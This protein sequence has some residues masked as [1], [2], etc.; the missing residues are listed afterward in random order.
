MASYAVNFT[1]AKNV[2]YLSTHSLGPY[3]EPS[4]L[5]GQQI[6]V[7]QHAGVSLKNSV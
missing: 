1:W 7:E 6:P 2:S 3:L 5:R 4:F